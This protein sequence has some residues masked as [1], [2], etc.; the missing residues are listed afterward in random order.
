ML[1]FYNNCYYNIIG[2]VEK[3]SNIYTTN[4][5][6]KAEEDKYKILKK[7]CSKICNI[8]IKINILNKMK[9]IVNIINNNK[10]NKL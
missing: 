1:Y 10:N 9:K 2:N 5:L 4:I 8:I 7:K 6:D 3:F